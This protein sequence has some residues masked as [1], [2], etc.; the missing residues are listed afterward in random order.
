MNIVS[1]GTEDKVRPS[2]AQR[3]F[4][5]STKYNQV[6]LSQTC[7]KYSTHIYKEGVYCCSLITH[8]T[9]MELK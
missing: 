5:P 4:L 3:W 7:I 9:L 6:C 8:G 2:K 1:H